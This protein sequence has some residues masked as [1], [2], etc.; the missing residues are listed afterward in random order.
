MNENTGI[1][2]KTDTDVTTKKHR[3]YKVLLH[4][5]DHTEFHSV[6]ESVMTVFHYDYESSFLIVVEAHQKNVA[7]C[8]VEPFEPAELHRDQLIA[9]KLTSTMEPE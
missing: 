9:M 1:I 6:I 5:D 4:N 3:L 8:K 7:L 2:E